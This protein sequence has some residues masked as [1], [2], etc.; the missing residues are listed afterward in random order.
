M[1]LFVGCIDKNIDLIEKKMIL[2][3]NF[4]VQQYIIHVYFEGI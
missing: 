1:L 2:N 4:A 3:V